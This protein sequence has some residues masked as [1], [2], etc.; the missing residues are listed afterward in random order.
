[1]G[2]KGKIYG[3]VAGDGIS[4]ARSLKIITA[5]LKAQEVVIRNA[6]LS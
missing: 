4:Y 6:A 3:T 1:M 5:R 2:K